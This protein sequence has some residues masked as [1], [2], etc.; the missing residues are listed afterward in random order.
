LHPSMLDDLGLSYA[1]KALAD[2]FSE[3]EKMVVTF[4]RQNVPEHIPQNVSATL[5]RITQEALRNVAKHAGRTHVKITVTGTGDRIR[6]EI[7]DFGEGFDMESVHH[8]LGLISMS[9]R[10]RLVQ[11][12]F[13][14]NSA[15]GKGTTLAV[16]VPLEMQEQ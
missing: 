3:R 15:L 7:A 10:A 6:L 16:E 1:L 8:G 5:Y 12:A 13:S 11:G 2:E 4:Q 9:E 14:V